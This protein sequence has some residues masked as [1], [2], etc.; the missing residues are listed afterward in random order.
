MGTVLMSQMIQK[1][2]NFLGIEQWN[3]LEK[4]LKTPADLRIIASSIQVLSS[5]HGWETW[6]N[7]PKDRARLLN[8]LEN[9]KRIES[10][11]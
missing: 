10:C 2:Q 4:S 8:L 3:W 1:K 9:S 5:N 7:F 6:G 11:N